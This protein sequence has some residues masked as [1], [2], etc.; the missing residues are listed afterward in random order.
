MP[1][2]IVDVAEP[3]PRPS[4]FAPLAH[5]FRP[6]FLAAALYAAGAIPAYLAW[7]SG[8]GHAPQHLSVIVWHVHEMLFG[9]AA[10]ALAG[11]LLTAVPNWTGTRPI[12]GGR[13][14]VLVLFWLLGRVA[15]A[16]VDA[17]PWG[18]VAVADLVFLPA[19]A[20]A[21]APALI[22]ANNRRNYLFFVL[23]ALLVAA[24]GLVHWQAG[25]VL[26]EA[27]RGLF[28]ALDTFLLMITV[29]S[30]RI[31]PAFTGTF[32]RQHR[33]QAAAIAPSPV[34]DRLCLAAMAVVALA[35]LTLRES[36]D[37][38]GYACLAAAALLGVRLG[39][40]RTAA[41]LGTPILLI[42][43]A[44]VL[45]LVLGLLAR[46]LALSFGLVPPTAA[47]HVL[48]MGAIGTMVMGVMSRATLGHGGRDMWA[49]PA[50]VM[51]YVLLAAAVFAR[52]AG[53]I[54]D[55]NLATHLLLA[56]GIL[57]TAAFGL[58]AGVI[59]PIVLLP[60][61]DGRPG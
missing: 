34:L 10:A 22:G 44:G 28:L 30:G 8:F 45:W 29:I 16:L 3:G 61:A 27:R 6:F 41:T 52:V 1:N 2:I 13:L 56:A 9:F 47:L 57:W 25:G 39:R 60:R 21:V 42:L 5:G 19:L 7:L 40:W 37:R 58:F 54:L 55:P 59:A 50:M 24:N 11:F 26:H 18:V 31:V 49:P 36:D 12:A 48:T 53:L 35:D 38:V 15:M 51:A 46:G 4:G 43:H 23:I 33:P 14:G 32:L 20:V 17:L